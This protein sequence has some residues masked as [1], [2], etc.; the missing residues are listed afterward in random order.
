MYVCICMYV[1]VCMYMYVRIF[2]CMYSAALL[3]VGLEDDCVCVTGT[4]GVMCVRVRMCVFVFTY[5]R[6]Y[7]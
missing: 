5:V 1:Y 6:I 2:A 4:A 7:I 3:V